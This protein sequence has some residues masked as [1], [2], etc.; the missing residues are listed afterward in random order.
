MAA[1]LLRRGLPSGK[2]QR[3]LWGIWCSSMMRP[4]PETRSARFSHVLFRADL[5]LMFCDVVCF[6]T[7]SSKSCL[8]ICELFAFELECIGPVLQCSPRSRERLKSKSTNYC[9]ILFVF[10][11]SLYSSMEAAMKV[12]SDKGGNEGKQVV[13]IVQQLME[14]NRKCPAAS[15]TQPIIILEG[16]DGTG[17]T[18]IVE[19]LQRKMGEVNCLRSPPDCLSSFRPHFDGQVPHVR[20][21]FYLVG[22]YAC[23]L[24]IRKTANKPIVIDR[25]WP[26][27]M[28]YALAIDHQACSSVS[29]CVDDSCT[30]HVVTV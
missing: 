6:K 9:S 27:T 15:R 7:E 16:L 2:R 24:N 12:L 3:Q 26:S 25:F 18:T 4:M 20:R 23:A 10:V 22:N 13:S 21:A 14:D 1:H 28:A 29:S 19:G 30:L 8:R 11:M 5:G 17:K